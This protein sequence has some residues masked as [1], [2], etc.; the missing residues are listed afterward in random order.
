METKGKVIVG[1]TAV[2]L[3][4]IGAE[5]A[6]IHHR[7]NEEIPVAKNP[8]ANVKVDPDDNV[9]LRKQ[10]PD[11]IKDERA[12]IGKTLWVSAAA[13]LDYYRYAGHHADYAHPVGTLP[14]A[15]PL[16]VKDV[17]EQVPPRQGRAVSRIAAG[18]RHV[19]LAFTL[20]G[21]SDPKAQYA[22][23][24]GNYDDSGYTFL[25]DD[26]F[27]YDDPHQL[28]D[29]WGPAM[30]AHIDK[31]EP[32]LG[33]S[34]NQAMLALGQVMTPHGDNPSNR[35]VTYDNNGQPITLD[36]SNGKAVKITPEKQ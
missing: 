4:A 15:L 6:I 36:F 10:H 13:Q 1:V 14:G 28:Y 25:T 32:A 3:V 7:N 35:S 8:Y 20:P 29:F 26:I 30:W 18:E 24:V 2:F 22:V 33:M 9:F 17:F 5:L 34:E 12:L 27:F 31:H 16:L 23:P 19:L 11:S 21:S